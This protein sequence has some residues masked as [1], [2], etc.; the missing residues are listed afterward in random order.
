MA[1]SVMIFYWSVS[2]CEA[3]YAQV[4]IVAATNYS[5][6]LYGESGTGKEVIAKTIIL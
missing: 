2:G 3:L 5:I 6:I 1:S 4:D